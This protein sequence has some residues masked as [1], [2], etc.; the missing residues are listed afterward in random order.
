M[1]WKHETIIGLWHIPNC[2]VGIPW[3]IICHTFSSGLVLDAKSLFQ[4]HVDLKACWALRCTLTRSIFYL[5][6]SSFPDIN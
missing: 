4:T 6:S 5:F 1:S 2:I 3:A